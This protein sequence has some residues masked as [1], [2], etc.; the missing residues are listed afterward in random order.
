MAISTG[1][2]AL[3]VMIE[4]RNDDA[5]RRLLLNDEIGADTENRRLQDEP[6]HLGDR[7]EAAGHVGEALLRVGELRVCLA[8]AGAHPSRHAQGVKH[9]AV[10]PARFGE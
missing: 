7:A 2:S 9:L 10:R 5:R 8:P 4:A 1:A 6:Q 3:A